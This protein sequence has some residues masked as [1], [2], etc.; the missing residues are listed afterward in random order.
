MVQSLMDDLADPDEAPTRRRP[1]R[2][3]SPLTVIGMLLLVAGFGCLG[4]V[5]W[6]YFGTNVTSEKAFHEESSQL[7]EEWTQPA[8]PDSSDG[9]GGATGKGDV[10]PTVIPGEAIALLR[11]PAFGS[12]YEVPILSGTDLAILDRGVGHYTTTAMPGEV[13]NFALAGHRVTHGEPFRRLLELD[14]G[15]RVIVETRDKIHTYVMDGS[16]GNLTV[17]DTETWVLD[18]DPHHPGA[19]A[20]EAVLTLTTCQDLFHSPDRSVGFAHLTKT[21]DKP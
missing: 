2:R 10:T 13:G 12:D 3:V 16:P 20:T 21:V 19:E 4:W 9:S 14:E 8:D 18:P 17:N 5:A 1:R 15:D 6:Q 11:I 7:R